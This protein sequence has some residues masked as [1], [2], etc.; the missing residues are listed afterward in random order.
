MFIEIPKT[1]QSINQRKPIYGIGINDA[2]YITQPRFKG[3]RLI[4]PF[5][6]KWKG[7]IERCYCDKTQKKHPT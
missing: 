3:K 2:A 1:E 4:C 7:I 5:Y 6:K